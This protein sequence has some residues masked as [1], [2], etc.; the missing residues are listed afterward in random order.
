MRTRVTG[1]NEHIYTYHY[2][3]ELE[4]ELSVLFT[5]AARTR[6]KAQQSAIGYICA[7]TSL[8]ERVYSLQYLLR[9]TPRSDYAMYII[10]RP[11]NN[12]I[13]YDRLVV[14]AATSAEKR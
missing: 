12:R 11:T 1:A 9:S 3:E 8:Q 5:R 14:E 4:V 2:V 13:A 6:D 10:A 7:N